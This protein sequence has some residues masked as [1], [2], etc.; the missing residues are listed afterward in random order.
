MSKK[1]AILV[2]MLGLLALAVATAAAQSAR[3]RGLERKE[4]CR[5]E[6]LR[7]IG[8]DCAKPGD[9]PWQVALEMRTGKDGFDQICGG[10]VIAARWVLTAAH[11]VVFKGKPKAAEDFLI[12]ESSHRLG[13]GEGRRVPVIRVIPH[14]GYDGQTHENDIAL[15][16]LGAGAWSPPVSFARPADAALETPGGAAIVTGWGLLRAWHEESGP[17]GQIHYV[18]DVTGAEITAADAP[19][20]LTRDLMQVELPV[21]PWQQCR[22][23][24]QRQAAIQHRPDPAVVDERVI[25]AGLSQ[26]G[27]DSCKGDSGGPLVAK[28]PEGYWIQIGIV[29]WGYGCGRPDAPGVYTR[30]S[31]PRFQSWLREKTGINQDQPS[32]E[33][34]AV[35]PEG[36]PNPARLTV[37]WVQGNIVRTGQVVQAK[38]TTQKRGYLVLLNAS[39]DGKITQY[40]PSDFS[41]EASRNSGILSGSVEPGS[42]TLVPDAKND[43]AGF[44]FT[45]DPLPGRGRLIA[46]LT[47]EKI[48]QLPQR[49]KGLLN[50]RTFESRAEAVRFLGA[51]VSRLNRDVE[52]EAEEETDPIASI[53]TFDYTVRP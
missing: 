37:A 44:K 23:A 5:E 18:D 32:P 29:S 40:Y 45:I 41:R 49:S 33:T 47:R 2:S 27:K 15:L 9:W 31:H 21:V 52:V 24:L 6:S 51:L 20:Y 8:G 35:L 1:F 50:L 34:Q 38:V 16:E 42:I 17:E 46:V 7:I 22:A 4:R 39:P 25:C 48:E 26:G 13:P 43:Y 10:S 19:K 11:C 36:A 12:V 28:N 53:A 30:L 14:E 3:E